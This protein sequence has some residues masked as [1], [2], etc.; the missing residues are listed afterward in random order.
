MIQLVPIVE[1]SLPTWLLV[2]CVTNKV[3]RKTMIFKIYQM[4]S[5]LFS[6]LLAARNA[7]N[8]Q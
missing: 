1:V 5:T 2:L 7:V 4:Y 6:Y 8:Y 3:S